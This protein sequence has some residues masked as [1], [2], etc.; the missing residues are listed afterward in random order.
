MPDTL[1]A[2]ARAHGLSI[3]DLRGRSQRRPI[4]MARAEAIAQ[5]RAKGLSL[6]AIGR[7]VARDHKAVDATLHRLAARVVEVE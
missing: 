5:L 6:R 7:I 4:R 3:A 2:V 1:T